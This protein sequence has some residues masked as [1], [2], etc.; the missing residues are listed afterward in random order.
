MHSQKSPMQQGK[1]V[2]VVA[3]SVY[4]VALDIRKESP[5]YGKWISEVL[6]NDNKRQLWIPEGFAHGFLS[7]ED[8]SQVIY[9][10]TNYYS[11]DHEEVIR[12][13][14]SNYNIVWPI[15]SLP[16]QSIKDST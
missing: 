2:K 15:K 16:I 9:K 11:K 5:S 13:D 10:T 3:G 4:D 14:D 7:L 1:L 8:N 12:Y 6:S